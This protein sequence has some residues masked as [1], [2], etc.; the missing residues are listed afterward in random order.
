MY[1]NIFILTLDEYSARH[2]KSSSVHHAKW[3]PITKDEAQKGIY[4]F[5]SEITD[6][7]DFLDKMHSKH[8]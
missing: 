4:N 2:K 1:C 5:K 6:I 7:R 8:E 3:E